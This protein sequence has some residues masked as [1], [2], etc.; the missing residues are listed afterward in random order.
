MKHKILLSLLSGAFVFSL[1]SCSDDDGPQEAPLTNIPGSVDVP[2]QSKLELGAMACNISNATATM[3]DNLDDRNAIMSP[4]AAQIGLGMTANAV[5]QEAQTDLLNAFGIG[6]KSIA[7][8]NSTMSTVIT[9]LPHVDNNGSVVMLSNSAWTLSGY[10][11]DN[12]V[13]DI[14][15]RS[16]KAHTAAVNLFSV[17]GI[18][19]INRWVKES[20]DG[21]VT[22]SYIPKDEAKVALIN[23][24]YFNMRWGRA[25]DAKN[26]AKA[27]FTNYDGRQV[28]TDMMKGK[29]NI[30]YYDHDKGTLVK[31]SY[32]NQHADFWVFMPDDCTETG[33]M[34]DYSPIYNEMLRTEYV[35]N[36]VKGDASVT[37][38]K[39]KITMTQGLSDIMNA[40]GVQS[41]ESECATLLSSD[42]KSEAVSM[43]SLQQQV[44]IEVDENGTAIKVVHEGGNGVLTAPPVAPDIVIDRPFI[45]AVE[46]Y[47]FVIASGRV[48]EL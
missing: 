13:S 8:L 1:S 9:Q 7:T 47:G 44:E 48:M 29:Q 4:L 30:T 11:F 40:L 34:R 24:L 32:K 39:F 2:N 23:A 26:T 38:P 28:Q 27:P 15:N 12:S 17:E 36:F 45:F 6:D 35:Q 37:M 21:K 18:N 41:L 43:N 31:I 19:Q 14:L 5:N 42:G 25:F 22:Y 20:T 16:Y 33:I 10:G 3:W 46:A